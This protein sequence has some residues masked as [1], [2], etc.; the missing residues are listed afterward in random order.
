MINILINVYLNLTNIN[1]VIGII[2][3]NSILSLANN[4]DLAEKSNLIIF[5]ELTNFT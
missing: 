4:L 2:K 1:L 3:A 5:L